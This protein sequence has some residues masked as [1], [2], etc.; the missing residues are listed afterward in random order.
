MDTTIVKLYIYVVE[1]YKYN[2]MKFFIEIQDGL[3]QTSVE[4]CNSK[5]DAFQRNLLLNA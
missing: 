3:W 4:I 2:P 1:G 5:I